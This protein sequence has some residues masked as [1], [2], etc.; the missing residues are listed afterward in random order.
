[1]ASTPRA[2]LTHVALFT[3]DQEKMVDFYTN[4]LGLTVTD[5]G[6]AQS[7]PVQM[8]FLS[9]D[10]S[11]HHQFVLIGGRPDYA[12][13]NVAQQIS[14]LVDSLDDLRTTR[15]HVVAA[16]LE[17]NRTTTHG[18]AWSIYFN[19]PDDNQI[20]VYVHT[21]WHVPQPHGYPFDLS[22]S[23]DEIIKQTEAHCRADPGF[24]PVVQR[25]KEIA[26]VMATTD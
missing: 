12:T 23:N 17:I 4:A 8:V 20:E 26:I 1:M 13:F 2:K 16:G 22:L 14:F 19:D 3:C 18:N 11:E 7:A 21:P 6:E 24:M 25:E 9:S 10:P 5:Q 15:D